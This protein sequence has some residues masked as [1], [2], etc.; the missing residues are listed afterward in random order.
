MEQSMNPI[1]FDEFFHNAP[2]SINLDAIRRE[3]L[4]L[5]APYDVNQW[6]LPLPLWAQ[7]FYNDS[8]DQTWEILQ[9]EPTLANLS[10]PICIYIHT[11]F[12]S[13][14]CG[15]CD[16][17]SFRL[18]N[19]KAERIEQYIDYLCA[20]L[21]MWSALGNLRHCPVS[22][23]HIGGG[24]P[25]YLGEAGLT[26]LVEWC[27]ESFAITPATEWALESTI[28]SLTPGM[29]ATMHDLGY[30]R[31]HI[32]VQSLETK[33]RAEIG[34][35]NTPAEVLNC[36][37]KTLAMGWI[38]SVD[39]ICGL[40]FQTLK[41]HIEGI[42][43]L[44]A[45]GVDG[46]SL[47][48]LLIYPQNHKWAVKNSLIQR[49]HLPNYFL[50]QAGAHVLADHGYGKNL[51][52]HWVNARDANIYFTFPTR[53]ED[54][55]AVGALADGVF[56]NYHYRHLGYALYLKAAQV[57][58]PGLAGGLRRT[59]LE[60]RIFPLTT[61]ILSGRVPPGYTPYFQLPG[62]NGVPLIEHW[63]ANALIETTP[64]GGLQLTTNGS[65][66][67]GNIVEEINQFI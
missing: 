40:P 59:A 15:F 34:R 56:G 58:F 26:R 37:T 12:C 63:L 64:N 13:S 6:R 43:A 19:H 32:G 60:D 49:N 52:N 66:F 50:F 42:E 20:E 25:T 7:R 46:F 45:A 3:W 36:I 53:G 65:W 38:V 62:A 61:A 28:E 67:A 33:V 1:S 54:C 17:Y 29:I 55:L 51:F 2:P 47:Y 23:V 5:S 16:S 44:I 18:K 41:G 27:R 35:R 31:L 57:G 24:T 21:R 9:Q 39:L 10:K 22:T 8:G 30:R 4:A 11:P 14:K 48:E